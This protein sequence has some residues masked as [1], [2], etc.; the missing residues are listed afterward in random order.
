LKKISRK[1]AYFFI[2]ITILFSLL[3]NFIGSTVNKNGVLVEP[4]F[5]I[6]LG[7]TSFILGIIFAFISVWKKS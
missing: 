6:P 1:L 4:F 3:F 5:L 2:S 7:Y